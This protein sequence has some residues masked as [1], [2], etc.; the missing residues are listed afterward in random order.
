MHMSTTQGMMLIIV[1]LE[2]A[3]V[4]ALARPF[5]VLILS[6]DVW[7]RR[8]ELVALDLVITAVSTM[9]AFVAMIGMHL[10]TNLPSHDA[11]K[12][13]HAATDQCFCWCALNETQV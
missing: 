6:K 5:T 7:C 12:D 10:H 11:A 9:F 4:S 8:N 1:V 2:A 13:N 3:A